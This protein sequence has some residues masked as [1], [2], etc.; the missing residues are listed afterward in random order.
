MVAME[1][2]VIHQLWRFNHFLSKLGVRNDV[3][4]PTYF[5]DEK[6]EVQTMS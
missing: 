1:V 5:T 2:S 6:T 4:H 3:L